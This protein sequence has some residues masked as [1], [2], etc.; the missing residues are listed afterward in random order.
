MAVAD[1]IVP[2]TAAAAAVADEAGRTS[3]D[4]PAGGGSASGS[5]GNNRGSGSRGGGGGGDGGN[6]G[7]RA[8]GFSCLPGELETYRREAASN[9]DGY[10]SFTL[11]VSSRC[12]EVTFTKDQAAA[13]DA[14]A[15]ADRAAAD[16]A[17]DAAA[18]AAA[19]FSA[20]ADAA[21]KADLEAAASGRRA[22]VV[23]DV[24]ARADTLTMA[25]DAAEFSIRVG[26]ANG[27]EGMAACFPTAYRDFFGQWLQGGS[28]RELVI[29]NWLPLLDG[30][31][32]SLWLAAADAEE[33]AMGS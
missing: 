1:G 32:A 11:A 21:L 22:A 23:R 6:E 28:G 24:R 9:G 7:G 10:A 13:F 33:E 16:A 27:T 15:A 3:D 20:A 29:S 26:V 2:D 12:Y 31:T 17:T 4:S 18:A 5:A 8:R 19:A 14:Q 25:A 30:R